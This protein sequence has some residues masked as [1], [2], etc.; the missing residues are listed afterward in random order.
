MPGSA[1]RFTLLKNRRGRSRDY[2]NFREASGRL[3][4]DAAITN[5]LR[6]FHCDPRQDPPEPIDVVPEFPVSSTVLPSASPVSS[7]GVLGQ[8]GLSFNPYDPLQAVRKLVQFDTRQKAAALLDN[9]PLIV[10]MAKRK[11]QAKKGKGKPKGKRSPEDDGTTGNA[12][13]K[14]GSLANLTPIHSDTTLSG[15]PREPT[16][17]DAD[18]RVD[19]NSPLLHL[20]FKRIDEGMRSKPEADVRYTPRTSEAHHVL[21]LPPVGDNVRKYILLEKE[22]A[23]YHHEQ[24]DG[25]TVEAWKIPAQNMTDG[26]APFTLFTVPALTRTPRQQRCRPCVGAALDYCDGQTP[27]GRCRV[28][29]S[30]LPCN[31][32]PAHVSSHN[33]LTKNVC[34][35]QD[36]I[37]KL[38]QICV[39][40]LNR[41]PFPVDTTAW[42]TSLE[43]DVSW[44]K[45]I[46]SSSKKFVESV[47]I[48]EWKKK[49]FKELDFD[50]MPTY[51]GTHNFW[52]KSMHTDEWNFSAKMGQVPLHLTHNPDAVPFKSQ[53]REEDFRSEITPDQA[54]TNNLD[55]F[56]IFG[57]FW[58]SNP[59]HP[60]LAER[61][62]NS[63]ILRTMLIAYQKAVLATVGM[64]GTSSE[65][66]AVFDQAIA[67]YRNK[68][69]AS[70]ARS[71]GPFNNGLL[72]LKPDWDRIVPNKVVIPFSK[73]FHRQVITS[74]GLHTWS[75]QLI[76]TI[77]D[78]ACISYVL[79]AAHDAL[80]AGQSPTW[81]M[82]AMWNAAQKIE[83]G[84]ITREGVIELALQSFNEQD[85][86]LEIIVY[87][88][89][90][91]NRPASGKFMK[92]AE[93]PNGPLLCC[94]T[95][96][97]SDFVSETFSY[98]ND[99]R[100]WLRGSVC[101]V[102]K[103]D[104][105]FHD[106]VWAREEMEETIHEKYCV[107]GDTSK[108]INGYSP[109]PIDLM[110]AQ[111]PLRPSLEKVHGRKSGSLHDPEDTIITWTAAN[112]FKWVRPPSSLP[113]ILDAE[114]LREQE[115]QLGDLGQDYHPSVRKEWER[116]ER[117]QD[118]QRA[119]SLLT[120]RYSETR[121]R[122]AHTFRDEQLEARIRQM[123]K[124]GIWDFDLVRKGYLFYTKGAATGAS[125]QWPASRAWSEERYEEL[126]GMIKKME[127]SPAWN[128]RQ[129]KVRWIG[130][131]NSIPLFWREDHFCGDEDKEWLWREYSA[132]FRT[133]N[134]HCDPQHETRESPD[135]FLLH[136]ARQYFLDG[137]R[138]HLFGFKKTRR[139]GYLATA[140]KGRG[141]EQTLEDG[142][143][144][145]I[146]P[147]EWMRTG[148]TKLHPTSLLDFD[149]HLLSIIDES[150]AANHM[151]W[152]YPPGPGPQGNRNFLFP[153]LRNMVKQFH[154][155][156]EHYD[157]V[158]EQGSLRPIPGPQSCQHLWAWHTEFIKGKTV[159]AE[160][161]EER[162]EV[163]EMM[164]LML[165]E[166]EAATQGDDDGERGGEETRQVRLSIEL[167]RLGRL[168]PGSDRPQ[169]ESL[170]QQLGDSVDS[171]DEVFEPL[172][173]ALQTLLTRIEAHGE[174][175]GGS[176]GEGNGS[177]TTCLVCSKPV[178]A[179]DI[180]CT[181][182]GHE[183]RKMHFRCLGFSHQP[184][185]S[186]WMCPDCKEAEEGF[187]QTPP[188]GPIVP[189]LK[190]FFHLGNSC[191]GSSSI[192]FLSGLAP[193]YS[194]ISDPRND[195]GRP[196]AESGRTVKEWI[197]YTYQTTQATP[198]QIANFDATH[199][200]NARAMVR[201]LR[202]LLG[203][204]HEVTGLAKISR[205]QMQ[206]FYDAFTMYRK[207][208]LAQEQGDAAEFL[209]AL[210]DGLTLVTDSST[211]ADGNGALTLVNN[212]LDGH[213]LPPLGL[214]GPLRIRS[215]RQQGRMTAIADFFC[216][217]WATEYLCQSCGIVHRT[218]THEPCW[219]FAFDQNTGD[220]SLKTLITD[221]R[222]DSLDE[223]NKFACMHDD[224]KPGG[225][226]RQ[227]RITHSPQYLTITFTRGNDYGLNHVAIPEYINI[228]EV[229]N[230]APLPSDNFCNRDMKIDCIYR[231]VGVNVFF[232]ERRHY[233]AY[234][235]QNNV[236]VKF[237]DMSM[238]HPTQEHPQAGI[239]A[240]GIAYFVIYEKQRDQTTFPYGDD[241]KHTEGFTLVKRGKLPAATV[242]KPRW[243]K[244][245]VEEVK[246][247]AGKAKAEAEKAKAEAEKA[248]A[249]A[250]KAK[251]EAEKA[252]GRERR[253]AA[254][255]AR[256]FQAEKVA[257][258]R[259]QLQEAEDLLSQRQAE[260]DS[261][262][263]LELADAL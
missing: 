81:I 153:M 88:C 65:I 77:R 15:N 33:W 221:W 96:V 27:C 191:Y 23:L 244:M 223:D 66:K 146:L 74:P 48:L 46:A 84:L 141:F 53:V 9:T 44:H 142:T 123:E 174:E 204:V 210:L 150:V 213:D 179:T 160:V 203:Q 190:N 127:N 61:A 90:H 97:V 107:P 109:V 253:A 56:H 125:E 261:C 144:R 100:S 147:K 45:L 80:R 182:A 207:D 55:D 129:F 12:P 214:E 211:R 233:V 220:Q 259:Q 94:A 122:E 152:N 83:S 242:E 219:Q 34:D 64:V 217:Q 208:L 193:L 239:N 36:K 196:G 200:K 161:A 172:L 187:G 98:A 168:D 60:D 157:A 247:A 163:A 121:L 118:H 6:Q 139:V 151:R 14:R 227:K 124:S 254:I 11:P 26:T 112:H 149:L 68:P 71:D 238:D 72:T 1:L 49:A 183:D 42:N 184:E 188:D 243:K 31:P 138:C 235:V 82:F 225:S 224:K 10:F 104:R 237:D 63:A 143:I 103:Q 13:K 73:E 22:V 171:A 180:F 195:K 32:L 16:R 189:L 62:K 134:E 120:S 92:W 75:N 175:G 178:D 198:E 201:A 52:S 212:D 255:K 57:R 131:D 155:S 166:M 260:V 51:N 38:G 3:T 240:K 18:I 115:S 135:T 137:G 5:V 248:K 148:W 102:F 91:C 67:G 105:M 50:N 70:A 194:F 101:R 245:T 250:E 21:D 8:S 43:A 37:V 54:E 39:D 181:T 170:V 222:Q 87:I 58:T 136:D 133:T 206:V 262:D 119:I 29:K 117:A 2:E 218:W 209:R 177:S 229:A 165:K 7:P 173:R 86:E 130:K 69:Q 185:T 199:L 236:W 145:D 24:P 252:A 99:L 226:S 79:Q 111:A 164:S 197:P 258:L 28:V 232:P 116:H 192:V 162:D 93:T 19:G 241:N 106:P 40:I 110:Q 159:L 251:A 108:A 17:D 169:A 234:V 228:A 47:G 85:P 216:I 41:A 158:P 231:L 154:L 95:C 76:T 202:K 186:D 126:V 246:A 215:Y 59:S 35:E 4:F 20:F 230:D 30:S 205:S 132:E 140:S 263:D 156:C 257:E 113:L 128:P 256:D 89:M 78:R 167:E 249:E 25:R 176:G 114:T